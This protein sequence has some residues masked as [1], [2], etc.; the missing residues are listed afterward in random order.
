MTVVDVVVAQ[1]HAGM[2][3]LAPLLPY[4]DYFLPNDDESQRLTG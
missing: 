3:D 2:D 1:D 4:T